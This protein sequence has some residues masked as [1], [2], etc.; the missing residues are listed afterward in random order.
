[1]MS[2]AECGH[3]PARPDVDLTL[4]WKCGA[5]IVADPET[6]L[7]RTLTDAERLVKLEAI[8]QCRDFFLTSH[9]AECS[10][11]LLERIEAKDEPGVHL[12]ENVF[13]RWIVINSQHPDLAWSG[14]RWVPHLSG[15]PAGGVQVSNF[16]I[17]EEA[18]E[19]IREHFPISV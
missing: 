18:L 16:T 7:W 10:K 8:R 12:A 4:C 19:Y 5:E 1:M 9:P 11:I 14:S 6:H 3:V 13:G 15:I 17:R 2:E